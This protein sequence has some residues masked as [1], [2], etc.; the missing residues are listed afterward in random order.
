MYVIVAFLCRKLESVAVETNFVYGKNCL[1][2]YDLRYHKKEQVLIFMIIYLWNIYLYCW[3]RCDNLFSYVILVSHVLQH[4][5]CIFRKLF[6]SR[7]TIVHVIEHYIPHERE[8]ED[9]S[10]DVCLISLSWIVKTLRLFVYV[11]IFSQLCGKMLN[12]W[13]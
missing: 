1:I 5:I 13:P 4:T 10:Y 12:L 7:V 3:L 11:C 6:C 8:R 9:L 2:E